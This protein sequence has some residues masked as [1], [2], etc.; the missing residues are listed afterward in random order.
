[1]E[2]FVLPII[3]FLQDIISSV[4]GPY[5]RKIGRH[6]QRFC[7]KAVKCSKNEMQK[8]MFFIIT[9][10]ADEFIAALI[11][12]DNK[13][14]V[15][16]FKWRTV[17]PKIVKRQMITAFHV[18][19]SALLTLISVQKKLFLKRTGMG[20][21]ELLQVWCSIFE[22]LPS[23]MQLFNEVLLPAYQ[24]K[25]IEGLSVVVGKNMIDQLFI[26]NDG[27]NPLELKILQNIMLEDVAAVL[28]P[29]AA[30]ELRVL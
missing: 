12:A 7:G 10:C 6:T 11:G 30:S 5:H 14:Q 13:R 16:H 15:E 1:M 29:L 2:V 22:Y 26:E 18:Y 20:E 19:I 3:T 27:L 9:I 21:Q 8:K 25:G 4:K 24:Q 23:D 28:R 17:K